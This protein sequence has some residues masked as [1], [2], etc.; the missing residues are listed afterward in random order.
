MACVVGGQPSRRGRC[1]CTA[2]AGWGDSGL[3]RRV[4]VSFDVMFRK[5]A[6]LPAVE[7][8]PLRIK[9]ARSLRCD[10]AH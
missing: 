10:S 2:C 7:V 8:W 1:D 5:V 9:D 4:T 6:R 3:R